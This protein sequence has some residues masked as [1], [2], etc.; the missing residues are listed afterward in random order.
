MRTST[1]VALLLVTVLF[2]ASCQSNQDGK[3][4]AAAGTSETAVYHNPG[5]PLRV[6]YPTSWT[7]LIYG[8][9]GTKALVAFLSP[10]DAKGERQHLA[11]DVRKLSENVSLE[12]MKDAIIAEARTVFPKFE[13]LSSSQTTLGGHPAYRTTYTAGTDNAAGRILQV[14]AIHDGKAYSAIYTTRSEAGFN[15]SLPQVEEMIR[16]VK[17]E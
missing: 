4:A 2:I 10:P 3:D 9:E 14:L 13:L 5:A 1:T 15:R 16:S 6:T 7:R 17:T 12:Q 11:F 8:Q